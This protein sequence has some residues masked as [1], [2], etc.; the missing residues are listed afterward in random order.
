MIDEAIESDE[1]YTTPTPVSGKGATWLAEKKLE[2]HK[3]EDLQYK[4]VKTDLRTQIREM[5]R[6]VDTM[7]LLPLIRVL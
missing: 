6:Q 7:K 5:R 2:A 1:I 3:Q 4:D